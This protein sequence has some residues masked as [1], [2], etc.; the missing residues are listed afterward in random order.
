MIG[1]IVVKDI[2]R[3][4]DV[5][6]GGDVRLGTAARRLSVSAH[7]MHMWHHRGISVGRGLKN[8]RFFLQANYC[9]RELRTRVEWVQEFLDGI[10]NYRRQLRLDRRY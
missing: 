6:P 8:K 2:I 9:G 1:R 5:L 10:A 3:E 7:A 4:T